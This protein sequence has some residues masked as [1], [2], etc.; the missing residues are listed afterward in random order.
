MTKRVI[1]L[2]CPSSQHAKNSHQ[3]WQFEQSNIKVVAVVDPDQPECRWGEVPVFSNVL[4][5]VSATGAEYVLYGDHMI[6][7]AHDPEVVR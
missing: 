5:A 1:A 3:S 4:R 2:V 7:C 6:S